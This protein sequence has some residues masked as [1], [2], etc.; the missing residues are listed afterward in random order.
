MNMDTYITEA[1]SCGT[2]V[3]M[4]LN[5]DYGLVSTPGFRA[6]KIIEYGE[7]AI[8]VYAR[9]FYAPVSGISSKPTKLFR[10]LSRLN[11]FL[12]RKNMSNSSLDQIEE[13]LFNRGALKLIPQ[14]K[15]IHIFG[16]SIKLIEYAKSLE[17]IVI[18]EGYTHPAYIREMHSKGMEVENEKHLWNYSLER[19][20]AC[21]NYIISPSTW[22]T[23]SMIRSNIPN[24][25][26]K[27]VKYGVTQPG[28][29]IKK[30]SKPLT[31]MFAGGLK[32]TKGLSTL[33]RAWSMIP[34]KYHPDIELHLYGR[35][36]DSTKILLKKALEQNNNI[37]YHGFERE[38]MKEYS[39]HNIYVYPS[40]FEGSSKTVFEA[41]AHGM[42]IITTKNSGSVVR[43]ET[44]GI[45][46][47][48]ENMEQLTEAIVLL[49]T[50]PILVEEMSISSLEYSRKFTWERYGRK[51]NKVYSELL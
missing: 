15:L 21:A 44:D 23:K 11:K 24:S 43:D 10:S 51:V 31:F 18:I 16:H 26:I 40:F 46:V 14:Y 4:I 19:S 6:H 36:F 37:F 9:H 5:T 38:L 47:D 13:W 29:R 3:L 20:F 27:E 17:K 33:L 35:R 1:Y 25:R 49:I 41:M 34:S 28:I 7:T 48:A 32:I 12:R 42:P 30:N 45:I 2:N 50:N 8:D 22:V 39:R